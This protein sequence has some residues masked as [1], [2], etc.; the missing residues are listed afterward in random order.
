MKM[1]K[2]VTVILASMVLLGT[3]AFAKNTSIGLTLSLPM[4]SV[5]DTMTVNSVSTKQ[6]EKYST[7]GIGIINVTG[8]TYVSADLSF[9]TKYTI[10][11]ANGQSLSSTGSDW[12]N[13]GYS[14]M[15]ANMLGGYAFK[16][17]DT[18]TMQFM[19]APGVHM[20]MYSQTYNTSYGSGR[21]LGL[22][23]GAGADAV[24]KYYFS[25][26]LSVIGSLGFA[27]DFWGMDTAFSN[28]SDYMK[29]NNISFI[30][31]IGIGFEY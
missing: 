14:W 2:K 11:N 5:T 17:V 15:F 9:L 19:I 4:E 29:Y 12:K 23:L 21:N 16:I 1:M 20:F 26:S 13:A 28:Y 18:G 6:T 30:P 7:I 3:A 27:Y 24:F 22:Y 31:R 8:F 25:G 10:V